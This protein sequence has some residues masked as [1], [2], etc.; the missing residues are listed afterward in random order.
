MLISIV[1]TPDYI[2]INSVKDASLFP[3]VHHFLSFI[4]LMIDILAKVK[5]NLNNSFNLHLYYS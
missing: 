5:W 3:H 1:T 2:P 4:F